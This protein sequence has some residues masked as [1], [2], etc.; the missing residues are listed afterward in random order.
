M[1]NKNNFIIISRDCHGYKYYNSEYNTPTIGNCMLIS[2]FI[3]FCKNIEN[4][5]EKDLYFSQDITSNYPL[6]YINFND[7]KVFVHFLHDKKIEQIKGKWKRRVQRL[8]NDIKTHNLPMY[9]FLNDYDLTGTENK[10]DEYISKFFNIKNGNKVFFCKRSTFES[11]SNEIKEQ[12]KK[13]KVIIISKKSLGGLSIHNFVKKHNLYDEIFNMREKN[14]CTEDFVSGEKF[15]EISDVCVYPRKILNKY[16]NLKNCCK[17]IIYIEDIIN[18]KVIDIIKESR[19]FFVK[20]DIM[21]QFKSKILP[22]ID[23]KF[24]LITHN[25]DKKSGLD[26]DIINNNFLIKWY[27]QNMALN[28]K[29]F[30]IPIGLANKQWTNS[31]YKICK[32]NYKT[33]DKKNKLVYFNFSNKTNKNRCIIE[34]IFIDKGFVKNTNK[35][36]EKYIEELSEHFYC[37]SPEGNGVDCHRIW[38]CIY[39]GTIPIVKKSK[40]MFNYFKGLPILWVDNFHIVTEKFLEDKKSLFLDKM[41]INYEKSKISYWKKEIMNYF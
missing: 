17:K 31:D 36:W 9:F 28:T 14:D 25:S 13:G 8:I 23:K 32:K 11:L 27:G 12:A 10:L 21:D 39:V 38:E 20:T 15:I 16:T 6:G 1:E 35:K 40:F 37:I 3:I 41:N 19:I 29:T 18:E 22:I 4:I 30:G 2:D 33:F 5:S 7:Y 24:I 26:K 34:K